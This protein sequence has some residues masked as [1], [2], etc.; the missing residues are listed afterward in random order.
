MKNEPSNLGQ[1]LSPTTPKHLRINLGAWMRYAT[2]V[3]LNVSLASST[4]TTSLWWIIGH[5]DTNRNA[6]LTLLTILISLWLLNI[7]KFRTPKPHK[8]S[9]HPK[10]HF[11][12]ANDHQ[13][14]MRDLRLD[15]KTAIFDGSNIY[16]F[17]HDNGLGTRPIALIAQ[18]LRA[19]KYRVICFFDANIFYTLNAHGFA[20]NNPRHSIADLQGLFGLQQNEIYVVPSGVQA[21]KYI[22][23]TLKHLPLSFA[24]TNDQ[25]RDYAKK[26]PTVMKGD[27][28]RKGV[29]ISKNQIKVLKHQFQNPIYLN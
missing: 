2:Y 5:P 8:N 21:D 23:D 11:L 1:K 19:E 15:T 24:I 18:Q 29:I 25:F 16:H 17:G 28:W 9:P 4:L 7:L 22:L 6:T 26:Y 3:I 12:L 14:I 13:G 20:P 10:T 27:Q